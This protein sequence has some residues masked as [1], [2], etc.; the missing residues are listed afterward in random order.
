[1]HRL[2]FNSD[3]SHSMHI[4]GLA[5]CMHVI[6]MQRRPSEHRTATVLC[7][8][9]YRY[10]FKLHIYIL[11]A[12]V[13][14][15]SLCGQRFIARGGAGGVGGVGWGGCITYSSISHYNHKIRSRNP[16]LT[17]ALIHASAPARWPLCHPFAS[18]HHS[19]H[20]LPA[21]TSAASAAFAPTAFA[22]LN[23]K[24]CS[25]LVTRPSN[26]RLSESRCS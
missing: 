16:P 19:P 14:D 4:N 17:A 18:C 11:I 8:P 26:T 21:R 12:H 22:F 23:P 25:T 13:S 1:M 10:V 2:R 5:G 20:K 9:P 3:G 6:R 7:L 15:L 24:L